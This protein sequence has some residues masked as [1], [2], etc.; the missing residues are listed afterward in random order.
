MTYDQRSCC[1]DY[2]LESNLPYF[3]R[4]SRRKFSFRLKPLGGSQAY[5][6]MLVI[7]CVVFGNVLDL[8]AFQINGNYISPEVNVKL[9]GL[10]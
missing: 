7:Q 2:I 10:Y 6:C 3:A 4:V 1:Y 9:I 8:G 5:T